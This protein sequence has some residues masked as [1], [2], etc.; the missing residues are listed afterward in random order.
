MREDLKEETQ[1][2]EE[3]MGRSKAVSANKQIESKVGEIMQGG[4]KRPM[5]ETVVARDFY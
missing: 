4:D 2:K 3:E 5:G 1:P